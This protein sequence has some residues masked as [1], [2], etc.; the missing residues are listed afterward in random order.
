MK[1]DMTIIAVVVV[2]AVSGFAWANMMGI[3]GGCCGGGAH[4]TCSI[5]HDQH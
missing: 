2:L 4:H 1:N 3:G 5:H